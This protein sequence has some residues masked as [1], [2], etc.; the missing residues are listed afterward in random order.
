MKNKDGN[1]LHENV[2]IIIIIIII[3]DSYTALFTKCFTI[4]I[5]NW[6]SS[7]VHSLFFCSQLL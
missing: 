3:I 2:I 6:V 1:H 4:I 5:P 7:T